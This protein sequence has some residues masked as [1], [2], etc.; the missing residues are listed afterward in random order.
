MSMQSKPITKE[1]VSS[2]IKN[3]KANMTSNSYE[4][5]EFMEK[6]AHFAINERKKSIHYEL[7]NLKNKMSDKARLLEQSRHQHKFGSTDWI[8]AIKEQEL[9]QEFADKMQKFLS[10]VYGY[11]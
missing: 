4:V 10:D 8:L 1:D 2:T 9:Y 5:L 7:L 11:N 6:S 3:I